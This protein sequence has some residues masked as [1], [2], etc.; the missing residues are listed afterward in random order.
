MVPKLEQAWNYEEQR[1]NFNLVPNVEN[2]FNYKGVDTHKLDNQKLNDGSKLINFLKLQMMSGKKG[3]ELRQ[4][5]AD[6]AHP[7]ILKSA[8]NELKKLSS[9]LGLLGN[10]YIDPTLF[11]KC[12]DGAD[13]VR[14]RA[15]TSKYV[16]AMDKCS[17]CSFNKEG[18]CDIYKKHLAKEVNYGEDTLGFYSKHFSNLEGKEVKIA[19]RQELQNKFSKEEVK[20]EK[21]AEFK[22]SLNANKEEE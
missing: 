14:K 9:E 13:F 18:R 15:K 1:S 22:P 4:I 21:I 16:V 8:F 12:E 3:S 11:T 17:G 6:R 19:S 7:E 5:L 2:D 10:V 20:K